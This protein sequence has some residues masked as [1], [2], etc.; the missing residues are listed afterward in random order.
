MSHSSRSQTCVSSELLLDADCSAHQ[1]PDECHGPA[2][3]KI[4]PS[5]SLRSASGVNIVSLQ[6]RPSAICTQIERDGRK[7]RNAT[8]ETSVV[9][10]NVR[11]RFSLP[12]SSCE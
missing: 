6:G 8:G 4:F 7:M 1:S 11:P 2:D 3:H 12:G 9:S 5:S 10:D